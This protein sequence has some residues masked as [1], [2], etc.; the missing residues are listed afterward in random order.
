MSDTLQI[1]KELAPID[2]EFASLK[3]KIVEKF[4]KDSSELFQE[5]WDF[6]KLA[7][8]EQRRKSGE[9]YI[10]H[11]L[12][13][14][15]TLFDWGLDMD[16]IISGL[17][18]DVIEDGGA[19]KDDLASKFNDDISRIVDGVSVVSNIRLKESREAF[20]VESLR[21]M[22]LTMA[23]DLRVVFVKLADRLHNM[24]TISALPV[25]KQH[26]IARE[27]LEV[28]APLAERL[29]MGQ[30][31]S[32]L[33]DLSFKTLYQEEHASLFPLLDKMTKNSEEHIRKMSKNIQKRLV[34]NKIKSSISGRKKSV[35][36]L[37]RKLKRP[38][39]AGDIE[40]VHD[41]MA[42]R[43][44][45]EELSDCYV[46]LGI[47]HSLYKPV[48]YLGVSDF[49]AQP[50]PN[51]YRS[52]HTKVFGEGGRIFEI[53][54]RTWEMHEQAEKG[55]AAHWAYA[56]AKSSGVSDS[57]LESGVSVSDKLAWVTQLASWQ[58]QMSDSGEF[59]KAV[60][61]DGL[62]QRN[63]VFT[64]KGDV[65]DLPEG[66]T[67]VDFAFA[68]HT[69]LGRHIKGAKV[70]GKVVP[71]GRKLVSGDV[72]EIIKN[73]NPEKPNRDWLSFVVTTAAR[74]GIRKILAGENK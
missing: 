24:Q 40:R 2:K 71:L 39:V 74:R 62:K 68:L 60:K 34:E 52:I 29:G 36:S 22:I 66:A 4:G 28:F 18:H 57:K 67:P 45:V 7:H 17:L 44:L 10:I 35:Y 3:E 13:T 27:T 38:E 64:P 25:N 14:A 42:M 16:T 73:K 20:F 26:K 65:Y 69:G 15:K 19:T 1:S 30:A 63:F 51:G 41:L 46:A 21:K 31:K 11:P 32:A 9:L 5:A 47:I 43:V 70:N 6:A 23:Q 61:F 56:E 48:P 50:K 12:A 72:V 37:W 58:K 54:I 49:I 53:Q 55:A 59:V 8:G 33:E